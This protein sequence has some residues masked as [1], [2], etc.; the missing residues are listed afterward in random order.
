M[1]AED[2][3]ACERDAACIAAPCQDLR[4]TR[5]SMIFQQYF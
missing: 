4:S 5:E 2:V 1:T 3:K